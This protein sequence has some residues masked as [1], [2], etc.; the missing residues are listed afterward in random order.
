MCPC[1]CAPLV[2][3][4]VCTLPVCVFVVV[5][6]RVCVS[7]VDMPGGGMLDRCR[8]SVSGHLA[9]VAEGDTRA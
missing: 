5:Y 9:A 6:V 8:L 2:S 1:G 3:I 7:R 4:A